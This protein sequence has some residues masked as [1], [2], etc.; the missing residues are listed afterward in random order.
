MV[1]GMKIAG[2]FKKLGSPFLILIK[3]TPQCVS[4]LLRTETD[5]S[6]CY[7]TVYQRDHQVT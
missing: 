3:P 6:L 5:I 2:V 7:G 1:A 4:N